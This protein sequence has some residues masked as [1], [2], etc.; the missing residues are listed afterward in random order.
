MRPTKPGTGIIVAYE[1]NNVSYMW[2]MLEN[3]PDSGMICKVKT[4]K[5]ME[6]HSDIL[7]KQIKLKY[8]KTSTDKAYSSVNKYN[9]K[10]YA[11]RAAIHEYDFI[12]LPGF[13][14]IKNQ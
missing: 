5:W 8:Y 3:Q 12:S 6:P 10:A 4:G 1:K 11:H 2:V 13:E 14:N 7:G 9:S